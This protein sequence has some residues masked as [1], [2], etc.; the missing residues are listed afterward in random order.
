MA[1]AMPKA[2][3][4]C[5][6]AGTSRGRGSRADDDIAHRLWSVFRCGV[7]RHCERL[8][9]NGSR[10]R[11][12]AGGD[13]LINSMI[14]LRAVRVQ[15]RT[16]T[17]GANDGRFWSLIGSDAL[18]PRTRG[19]PTSS[20]SLW[21]DSERCAEIVWTTGSVPGILVRVTQSEGTATRRLRNPF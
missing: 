16:P 8:A 14:G 18:A 5:R 2:A 3:D 21:A 20:C 9:G 17:P 19:L 11:R 4:E 15:L 1:L 6:L 12:I 13:C 10:T 7:H